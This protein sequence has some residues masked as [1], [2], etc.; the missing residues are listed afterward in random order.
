M[1]GKTVLFV[2][3]FFA[4]ITALS[5]VVAADDTTFQLAYQ[6]KVGHF[7][8]Y[9][10]VD[11]AELTTQMANNQ[12]K[13]VQKTESLRAFRVISVDES[14]GAILEPVIEC[15]RMSSQTGDKAIVG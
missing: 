14:G 10:V 2:L 15:V 8:H 11:Q 4:S 3:G 6:F 5:H 12:A 7:F 9:E 13:A 1:S